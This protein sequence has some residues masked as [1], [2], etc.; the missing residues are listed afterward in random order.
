[1]STRTYDNPTSF[2]E[3]LEHRIRERTPKGLIVSRTRQLV[4]FCLIHDAGRLYS[5]VDQIGRTST[6]P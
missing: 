6:V 5:V 1:M 3:A 4:V 2:K